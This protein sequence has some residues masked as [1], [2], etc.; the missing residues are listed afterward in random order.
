MEKKIEPPRMIPEGEAIRRG[1]L[2]P[3]R[4]EAALSALARGRVLPD[5]LGERFCK[6]YGQ[7]RRTES[8]QYHAQVSH[9]D[10]EWYLRV[11]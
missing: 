9:L 7:A 1:K 8:E 10:Y 4:W 3:N 2:L 6:V 11:L 5:Y